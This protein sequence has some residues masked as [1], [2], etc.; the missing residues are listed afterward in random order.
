MPRRGRSASPPARAPARA[1]VRAAAP[2]PRPGMGYS[3][4]LKNL[5][6]GF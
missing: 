6:V 3:S 1:P 4:L 2:P 5:Q